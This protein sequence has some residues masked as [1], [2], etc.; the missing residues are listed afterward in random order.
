MEEL[1]QLTKVELR[2][3]DKVFY[4]KIKVTKAQIV[5]YYIKLAPKILPVIADRP[6]VLTR[7]PDGIEGEKV[8]FFEKIFIY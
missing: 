7:Y 3:L 5:E 6:L 2:N 8:S 4:P 1:R